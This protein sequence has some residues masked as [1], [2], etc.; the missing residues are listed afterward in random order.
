M[1]STLEL[2]ILRGI[3][4]NEEFTRKI[5][6]YVKEEYFESSMGRTLYTTLKE[7]FVQYESRPTREAIA[8]Q[9][10]GIAGL[11]DSEFEELGQ[12]AEAVFGEAETQTLDFLVDATEKWCKERAVYLALLESI[13]IHDGS[14]DKTRDA[15]P[16]L[17]SS[18]SCLVRPTRRTRLP[19]RL[20][21]TLRLLSRQ[22]GEN[23]LWTRILR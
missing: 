10:E 2:T 9:L 15:I 5:L 14:G 4:H 23:Q 18:V 19:C 1:I 3:V 6:P 7:F 16:T 21:R 13:S 12:S 20:Q 8:I 17:L 11:N 22:R